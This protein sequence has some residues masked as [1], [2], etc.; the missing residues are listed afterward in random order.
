MLNSRLFEIGGIMKTK[1]LHSLT[2]KTTIKILVALIIV[3]A[4][5]CIAMSISLTGIITE[6]SEKQLALLADENARIAADYLN[7][8]EQ[9]AS[10]L[11]KT[12][13]SY[14]VLTPDISKILMKQMFTETLE[15]ER[16][17]GIFVALEPS[18]YYSNT[19]DGYSFY[20]YRS[21]TGD[22]VY[23]NYGYADYKDGE[24][25]TATKQS[26]EPEV[27]EPY[28]WT[29][30]NGQVIWLISISTPI[31]DNDGNFLGVTNC[32]VT[33][34]TIN[35]L[36]YD[37][38]GYET[39]YS[40]I[41]TENGNYV[42]QST[43]AT[44]SGTLYSE[45]GDAD[46]VIGLA[47]SG[48]M[49]IFT[50]V[51]D[52]YGGE[53]YKAQ[54]PLAINDINE[55]WSST[56]V[57]GKGEVLDT[58][59]STINMVIWIM[60]AGILLLGIV[61]AIFLRQSLKPVKR[62][63]GM[64]SDLEGGNLSTSVTVKAKDELGNLSRIFNSTAQTLNG[65]I[66]EISEILSGISNGD[67]TGDVQRDYAGEFAPIKQALLT[68]L[69]TLNETFTYIKS[70]AEEVSAGSSQVASGAQSLAAAA[71]EQAGGMQELSATISQVSGDVRRNAEN[72]NVSS[73]YID[74][75]AREVERSNAYMVSLLE[76]IKGINESS[77]RIS[78]IIKIIDDI[79]FQTNI[80][81]LNAAVEAARAGQAGKGFAVVAEEVRN[82]AS[83]SANAAAQTSELINTS[84]DSIKEGMK[85]SESTA[86]ALEAVAEKAQLVEQSNQS[87]KEASNA[88]AQAIAEIELGLQQFSVSIQTISATSEENAATSEQI[89]SQ[90]QILFEQIDRYKTHKAGGSPDGQAQGTKKRALFAEGE[91]RPSN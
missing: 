35:N 23:E 21:E 7:T 82:L 56:F 43:D 24:F 31:L 47:Q 14:K 36:T 13:Q 25:Y 10:M 48:G 63:V 88:Q 32:D 34:D 9:K 44:K 19:P 3:M 45:S 86:A 28:P 26:L 50:S 55:L 29:L 11:S 42:V 69:E 62:L 68:I 41:L 59:T 8:L 64:A 87:I 17:F 80:L 16:I 15:D 73:E 46:K 27:C 81:A 53:A 4:S 39:A 89:S 6:Q 60:I 2:F 85:L 57:V 65:Y 40:Y 33:V 76:A 52:V 61:T 58:V 74:Q 5:I 71:T 18:R 70:A 22:L 12:V 79:S 49:E 90:A 72:V 83:K 54:I 1:T 66:S 30:T 78:S 51:N 37:M 91:I 67:L 77:V 20:A 38:G 84:I 75:V